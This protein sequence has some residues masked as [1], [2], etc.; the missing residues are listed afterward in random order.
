MKKVQAGF[1]LIELMIVIAIV[2]IL[3]AVALPAYQDYTVRARLS[4]ALAAMGPARTSISEFYATNSRFPESTQ[5]GDAATPGT[6][7]LNSDVVNT[8]AWVATDVDATSGGGTLTLTTQANPPS[9]LPPDAA[10]RT[11]EFV[12]A[13]VLS[14]GNP[15]GQLQ[16]V[17]R[18]GDMEPKYLP[19]NCRNAAAAPSDENE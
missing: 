10:A 19:A 1:T 3:A 13:P 16:W 12:A 11:I 9:S 7:T 5:F 4:E 15:T 6:Q 14:G 17:C 8:I 2:G 18:P